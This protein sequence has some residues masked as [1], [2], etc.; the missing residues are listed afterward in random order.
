MCEL[1]PANAVLNTLNGVFLNISLISVWQWGGGLKSSFCSLFTNGS[2]FKF[3]HS[4]CSLPHSISEK[5]MIWV[6]EWVLKKN[7]QEHLVHGGP[8]N[9]NRYFLRQYCSKIQKKNTHNSSENTYK[10]CSKLRNMLLVNVGSAW[11]QHLSLRK[12]ML[13]VLKNDTE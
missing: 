11:S 2:Y 9:R 4:Y 13:H 1:P 7:W 5:I 6:F 10:L 3:S 12:T 8:S